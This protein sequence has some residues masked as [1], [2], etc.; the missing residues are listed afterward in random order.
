MRLWRA[1]G[2]SALLSVA[3]GCGG[4]SGSVTGPVPEPQ[5]ST[6]S[7]V[8]VR[9]NSFS[10]TATT[11]PAGTTVTWTWRG[12][13]AHDVFFDGGVTSGA[14]TTGTYSRQFITAGTY[15]YMCSIHGAAMSG[16]VV[17]Q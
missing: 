14:K 15:N 17:V 8:D 7:A 3:P 2:L 9:D 12:S 5:P 1:M 4:G 6:S 13:N 10:P 16:Q 11:V